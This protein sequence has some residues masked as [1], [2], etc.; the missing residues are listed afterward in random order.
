MNVARSRDRPRIGENFTRFVR[1]IDNCLRG[2]CLL[3]CPLRFVR[4]ASAA[5][6]ARNVR[7]SLADMS[8][9]AAFAMKEFTSRAVIGRLVPFA[10]GALN[11]RDPR[12]AVSFWTTRARDRSS[13]S[14]LI[15]LHG[16][17]S[18]LLKESALLKKSAVKAL[19]RA[20]YEES[21]RG[22]AEWRG[23]VRAIMMWGT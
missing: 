19:A 10:S 12:S 6:D 23:A 4:E 2:A 13:T 8:V 20:A 5:A 3:S 17:Q 21:T 1:C 7:K 15:C 22:I 11:N 9:P 14:C 18:R 16:S